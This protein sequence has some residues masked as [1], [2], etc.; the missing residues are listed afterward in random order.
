LVPHSGDTNVGTECPSEDDVGVF[1]EGRA[2]ATT[3]E[4]ILGHLDTCSPC[5]QLLAYA[6]RH[7][8]QTQT[9]ASQTVGLH[10]FLIGESIDGRYRICRFMAR[11]GMGEVYEAW[12]TLLHEQIALK[13]IVCT[14]LDD[15]KLF[16]RIRGEVQLARKVTHH[17]VCRILEFGLH[18]R[19]GDAIPY[20]TMELL[21]GETLAKFR[22]RRSIVPETEALPIALQILDGLAAIHAAGIVHRDFK[23]E[24]VFVIP[25]DSG[26][27]R[28]VVTDFGLARSLN[29]QDFG[30]Q[31]SM[32]TLVGTPAY[33][34][35][36][37]AA[38]ASATPS[39]DIYAFGVLMFELLTGTLPF[40]GRTAIALALARQKRR[41]PT[42]TALNPNISAALE[43]VVA[44][45]LHCDPECRYSD[46]EALRAAMLDVGKSA[47]SAL[48]YGTAVF[49]TIAAVFGLLLGLLDPIGMFAK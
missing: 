34:A 42:L 27:M 35:P 43:R 4:K 22:S 11:G 41:A 44:R 12:D 2:S 46:V 48:S 32:N 7:R 39:W 45:C 15:V 38:G 25:A 19:N 1:I 29:S 30:M 20:F 23:P 14:A 24:N 8:D 16:A 5:R 31:S 9:S 21:G 36:E 10:T 49:W 18:H 17:N 28:A 13:T 26:P 3:V 6:A 33:M 47:S 40:E 37:Q